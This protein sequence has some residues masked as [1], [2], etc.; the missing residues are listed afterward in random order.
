MKKSNLLLLAL[1]FAAGCSSRPELPADLEAYSFDASASVEARLAVMPD[2]LLAFHRH[3]DDMPAYTP[4]QP[5]QADKAL[6]LEYLRL[7]PPVYEKVFRQ[8]CLG[9]YF[10][11][12]LIGNGVTNWI[13]TGEKT[14]FYI[15][16]NPASLSAGLSETLT[17]RERSCFAPREGWDVRVDAGS[18]YK[19]LLYALIHE[20]TH[21]LDYTAGVTPFT[22]NTMPESFRPARPAAGEFFRARWVD[23]SA[24]RPEFDFSGRD[25]ITFYGFGGGPLLDVSAAPGLYE[26]MLK[27]GFVSLYGARSWAESLADMATFAVLTRSL[28]QPYSITVVSPGKRVVLRPLEGSAGELAAEALSYLERI[29]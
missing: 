6:V 27:R 12:G 16:L 19:G 22:D 26:G 18:K 15:I 4:Y 13:H 11:N 9:I 10:M 20:G 24:P 29:P 7:L 8:R 5:S 1:A 21:G 3:E 14:Y 23:Y 25:K 28:G 17:Q 2:A